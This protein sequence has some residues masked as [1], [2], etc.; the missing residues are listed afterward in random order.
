MDTNAC[1]ISVESDSSFLLNVYL[2]T[3]RA[4]SAKRQ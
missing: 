3:A 2:I 1:V 4:T